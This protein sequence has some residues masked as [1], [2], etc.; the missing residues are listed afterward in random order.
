MRVNVPTNADDLIALGQAI[1]EKHTALGATSPLKGI[2][3]I[4]LLGSLS[5]SADTSNKDAKEFARKQETANQARDNALGQTGQLRPRTVRFIVTSARDVLLGQNK[6][7][8]KNLG[9]WNFVVDDS[10][11]APAKAKPA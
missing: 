10:A 3:D 1:K 9:D 2:E 11:P 4:D 8:E 7:K 6:G 5:D